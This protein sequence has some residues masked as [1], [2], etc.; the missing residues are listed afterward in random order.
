MKAI[1]K[2]QYKIWLWVAFWLLDFAIQPGPVG[3]ISLFLLFVLWNMI[4][5][6]NFEFEE[7]HSGREADSKELLDYIKRRAPY[8][9]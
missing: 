9:K 1:T 2:N 8:D 7:R 3:F 4:A 6:T 5:D